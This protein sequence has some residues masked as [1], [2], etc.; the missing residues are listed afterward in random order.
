MNDVFFEIHSDLPREAPG[1]DACTARALAM[2]PDLPDAP[3]T[4]DIGCGPGA[5]TLVLARQTGGHVTAI[6]THQPYLHELA[7]RAER[8]GL[9]HRI[10]PPNAS[11]SALD[12]AAGQFDLIWSEGAIYIMGFQE[13]LEAWR[14][15]LKPGGAL[16]VTEVSWLADDPPDEPWR[17]WQAGYPAMK[18]VDENIALVEAA[19]YRSIGHFA[20]PESAWWDDYYTPIEHRLATLRRQYR[21]DAEALAVLDEEAQEIDLYRRFSAFYGYVFYIM[22]RA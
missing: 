5:Q 22:V 17:F 4:L 10:N 16:A 2:I 21:D 8:A 12:F 13:G 18:T 19:G 14:R 20:L 6:D 11:M 7:R 3:A 15:F 9:S 1:S